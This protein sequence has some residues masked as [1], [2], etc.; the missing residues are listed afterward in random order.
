MSSKI[1]TTYQNKVFPQLIEEI[2]EWPIYKLSKDRIAFVEEITEFTKKRILETHTNDQLSNLLLQTSFL[3]RIRLKEELWK[4]DPPSEFTFFGKLRNKLANIP[5]EMNEEEERAYY[6]KLLTPIINRYANEIVG[7]FNKNTF[8]FARKFLSFFFN[9]LLNTAAGSFFRGLLSKKY[10]LSQSLRL[11]GELETVRNLMTKGTVIVVPT[12]FSNLDSILV[13]YAMDTI[14]GLPSFS[15]GAGLNLYNSG[16]AAFFMNRLGAYRVDRRKKN[17]IYLETLK[18][19][20]TLSVQ[21][22]TNSL[23]FPGGT[24]SRSGHLEEKLKMGLLGTIVEAQRAVLEKGDN[25]KIFIVPM[26]I[27]YPFVL[28]AKFLMQ[29]HL[30][31][32]GK[33][34]YIPI[35]DDFYS[36]RRL[37]RFTWEFFSRSSNI[38]L[39]FGK[40]IDVIGN[41]V[42]HDGESIDQFGRKLE[43]KD[44]FTKD[45]KVNKDLQ[46]EQEYTITLSEQIVKRYKIENVVLSSHLISYAVFRLLLHKNPSLD[47]FAVLRLPEEDFE[48]QIEDVQ[49]I[50]LQ[51]LTILINMEKD[52]KIRLAENLHG[53]LDEIIRYGISKM[54]IYHTQKP[55]KI[56]KKNNVESED[57]VLLHYYH[58]RLDNYG[59][60]KKLD[61]SKIKNKE[62]LFVDK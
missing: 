16:L 46:R 52:G 57:F 31:I 22:G 21:R 13:G 43:M 60:H 2:E 44:Y 20:S 15:Y 51:L 56:N 55:L 26:V 38:S 47:I 4:V 62:A 37:F 59:F 36:I 33:E 54:S 19:M 29:Q 32:V 12:H 23:F 17:G 9:R 40:P 35:R 10:Q 49:N 25:R 58:N 27:S 18:T 1:N 48:F 5:K 34:K 14:V 11:Y 61:W 50:V 45:G 42:N 6:V 7:T 24:R 8:L 53:K 30:K 41:I 28:E 39:S 3:E